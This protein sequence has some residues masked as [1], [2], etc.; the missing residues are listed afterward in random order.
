MNPHPPGHSR[1]DAE[2]ESTI[3]SL[4]E[5]RA[6]GS[7]IC[8]SDAARAVGTD[9]GWRDLMQPARDA[10]SRLV[11]QGLV[12]ITQ[13]GKVVDLATAKGPIRI[14]RIRT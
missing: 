4:L 2:L 12:E 3:L 6:A 13:G 5:Q 1:T 7:T 8:P 11:E 10:A 9:A 14:R